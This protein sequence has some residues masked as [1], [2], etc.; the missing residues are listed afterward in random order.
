M[1]LVYITEC[2][3]DN[4]QRF[5]DDINHHVNDVE[6]II[7]TLMFE[8]SNLILMDHKKILTNEEEKYHALKG[9]LRFSIDDMRFKSIANC[10]TYNKS[11]TSVEMENIIH[12]GKFQLAVSLAT[13]YFAQGFTTP[14]I[15]DYIHHIRERSRL[16]DR[17]IVVG[18]TD[19]ECKFSDS[20]FIAFKRAEAVKQT[21][22]AGMVDVPIS[23][24]ARPLCRFAH[25]YSACRRVEVI[26]IYTGA[27][28]VNKEATLT[29]IKRVSCEPLIALSST[30]K[31]NENKRSI[32]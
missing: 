16:A 29:P 27:K 10:K 3:G 26:A 25:T 4:Q 12:E 5:L 31:N 14:A 1:Y 7:A 22:V 30:E 17:L 32:N 20:E 13:I 24:I 28:E 23:T 18:Y 2:E 19:P 11:Y 8:F 21:L 9:I 6:P 15:I